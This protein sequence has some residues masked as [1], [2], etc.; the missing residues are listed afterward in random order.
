MKTNNIILGITCA[1]LTGVV[2]YAAVK[3]LKKKIYIDITEI[4][5]EMDNRLDNNESE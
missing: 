1:A 5:R 4:C 3:L 2:A